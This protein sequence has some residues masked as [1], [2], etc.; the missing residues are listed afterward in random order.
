VWRFRAALR[1]SE[2]RNER[3]CAAAGVRAVPTKRHA[4]LARHGT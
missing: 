2:Q 3:D 4:G 1:V